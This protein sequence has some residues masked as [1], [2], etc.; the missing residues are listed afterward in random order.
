MAILKVDA[1][2]TRRSQ[3]PSSLK[4]LRDAAS[5]TAVHITAARA[6]AI[7]STVAAKP[8]PQPV[9]SV[10]PEERL[11]FLIRSAAR[12]HVNLKITSPVPNPPYSTQDLRHSP[13]TG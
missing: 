6:A 4:G 8:K 11:P 13:L 2:V 1:G 7:D 5:E 10:L 3:M 9:N 12:S